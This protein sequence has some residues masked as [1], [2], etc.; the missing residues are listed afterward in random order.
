[1]AGSAAPAL[2]SASC[3]SFVGDAECTAAAAACRR[4]SNNASAIP[5]TLPTTAAAIVTRL[6]S[7]GSGVGV[8]AGVGSGIGASAP[9]PRA[10]VSMPMVPVM[11]PPPYDSAKL[12]SQGKHNSQPGACVQL[13]LNVADADS[14]KPHGVELEPVL[15][16]LAAAA[17]AV[18]VVAEAEAE[19]AGAAFEDEVRAKVKLTRSL[20]GVASK[21]V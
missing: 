19:A 11:L 15:T 16:A 6:C 10:I 7:V 14:L 5:P 20:P 2:A 21:A 18:A 8:G 3:S 9:P 17:V 1:M 13:S 4:Q 12:K